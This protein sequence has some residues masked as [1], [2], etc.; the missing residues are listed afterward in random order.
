LDSIKLSSELSKSFSSESN[1]FFQP[2]FSNRDNPEVWRMKGAKSY[3]ETVTQKAIEVLRGHKPEPLPENV[4]RQI[5][6]IAQKA[7]KTLKGVR[8]KA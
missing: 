2:H 3:G 8:F 5:D 7:E 4:Q 1:R 6:Q